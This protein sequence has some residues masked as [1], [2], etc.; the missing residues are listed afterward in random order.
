[1][2][3]EFVDALKGYEYYLQER[4]EPDIE[5]INRYL[6][7]HGRKPIKSRTYNHY[8]KLLAHGF[9]SYIPINQFDVF[10]TLGKIQ[11]AADRRR[12]QRNKEQT[13][14]KIS[15]DSENWIDA[16]IV[17]RSLVG[18]GIL[19][20]GKFPVARGSNIWIRI[21]GYDDIP[22]ILVWRNY[23]AEKN[24]TNFG[25]RAFEFI[26]KYRFTEENVN[27]TRL[28]GVLQISREQDGILDWAHV[29]RVIDKTNEL[30]EAT[31]ALIRSI[32][33]VLDTKINIARPILMSIKFGSPGELQ[34]K[35]DFGIADI[36]KVLIEKLQYW[37]EDK[38]KYKEE[39]RRRE[40]ENVNYSIEIARNAVNFRS[41][42]LE[43]GMTDEAIEAIM[44]P[45]RSVFKV[46][47]LPKNLFA[48]GTLER[49]V[50]T[51]RVI[52]VVAELV[53]GD[54]P[55]FEVKAYRSHRPK[56]RKA[57]KI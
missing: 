37:S 52:P 13:P 42:A 2:S 33:E 45:V 44:E 55:D 35:V 29:Y 26:A 5:G 43:A 56:H 24:E 49:G 32:D 41:E 15:R 40:L 20:R 1:M 51:E 50:L 36:L 11:M 17:D 6:S 25:T 31:D 12:Y 54:D 38:R 34:A 19:I 22:A 8:R 7:F 39:N 16:T 21:E 10:Q 47:K 14:A 46:K 30:L 23:N 9:R 28:T 27:T 4:G 3:A 48:M 18:F 53:A 57:R